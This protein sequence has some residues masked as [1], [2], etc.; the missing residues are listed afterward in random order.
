MDD[1]STDGS[2]S[3][4]QAFDGVR[5]VAN[6][7]KGGAAARNLGAR[8]TSATR[9]AFLDQD[10]VWHH[11]HLRTLSAAL[12]QNPDAPAAVAGSLPFS[13]DDR[14]G[15]RASPRECWPLDVWALF[16]VACP[17]PTPSTVLVR[18][19]RSR[20]ITSK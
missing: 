11:D 3:V 16:P 2:P 1:G 18:P 10:D 17:I 19:P 5:L 12:D 14:P 4:V 9:V 7:T 8:L 20:S 13:G 15:L 6:D